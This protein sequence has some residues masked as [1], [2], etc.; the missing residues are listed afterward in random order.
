MATARSSTGCWTCRLRR[1]KCD[2]HWPACQACQLRGLACENQEAKPH[3]MDGGS[4]QAKQ[5]AVVKK[6]VKASARRRREAWL[7]GSQYRFKEDNLPHQ[8]HHPTG[9]RSSSTVHKSSEDETLVGDLPYFADQ[10]ETLLTPEWSELEC[11]QHPQSIIHN[12]ATRVASG[13]ETNS[14]NESS[15]SGDLVFHYINR[16]FNAQFPAYMLLPHASE[17]W[18]LQS[19]LSSRLVSCATM[20][21]SQLYL[22]VSFKT[23]DDP[24]ASTCAT[25]SP[26][27]SSPAT[28]YFDTLMQLRGEIA[29]LIEDCNGGERIQF[30]NLALAMIQLIYYEI[31]SGNN[32]RFEL[33]MNASRSILDRALEMLQDVASCTEGTSPHHDQERVALTFLTSAFTWLDISAV[34]SFNKRDTFFDVDR[35]LAHGDIRVAE[36][37]GCQPWILSVMIRVARLISWKR[38]QVEDETLDVLVFAQK[39]YDIRKALDAGLVNLSGAPDQNRPSQSVVVQLTRVYASACL[40]YL[41]M[42]ISATLPNAADIERGVAQTLLFVEAL[43]NPAMLRCCVWPFCVAGCLASPSQAPRFRQL[44]QTSM[45][46]G[47]DSPG[48]SDSICFMERCWELRQ[49]GASEAV[50]WLTAMHDL[51]TYKVLL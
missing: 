31:W 33:H 18:I 12:P 47:T 24:T 43:D 30:I 19:M 10:A 14:P 40:L 50:N 17:G 3:W 49:Q 28:C 5:L 39:A 44:F 21:V 42:E 9:E 22:A 45:K 36:V 34:V 32:D 35:I 41:N 11:L 1:K 38:A 20:S 25:S 27:S 23:S 15:Y 4:R 37:T 46:S 6:Q 29:Q 8:S 2:E 26:A 7:R 51:G 13:L 16:V 48:L